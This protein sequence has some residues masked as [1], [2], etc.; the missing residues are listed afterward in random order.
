[1]KPTLKGERGK[2]LI[3]DCLNKTFYKEKRKK[4]KIIFNFKPVY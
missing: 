3:E 2:Q 1:M 4:R